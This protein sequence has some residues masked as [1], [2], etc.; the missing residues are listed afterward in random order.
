R[1]EEQRQQYPLARECRVYTNRR[2]PG[3][4]RATILGV[5]PQGDD[6]FD[7]AI[8]GDRAFI[9]DAARGTI[10]EPGAQFRVLTPGAGPSTV[11]SL[12]ALMRHA[13]PEYVP[14]DA[15]P[16]EMPIRLSPE[17]SRAASLASSIRRSRATPSRK[18][19]L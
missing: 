12:R 18:S 6:R 9:A 11:L 14:P 4:V 8:R 16:T 5:V 15:G 19:S 10:I 13:G 3:R 7:A 2:S 17:Q 1:H